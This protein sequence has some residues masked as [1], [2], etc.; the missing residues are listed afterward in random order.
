MPPGWV[1]KQRVIH[2]F[3][4][5]RLCAGFCFAVRILISAA[6]AAS[7]RTL[8]CGSEANISQ[9]SAW[10]NSVSVARRTLQM[11]FNFC[12]A[13]TFKTN[14]NFDYAR[15][16]S[17]V[18][19]FSLWKLQPS[20]T[21]GIGVSFRRSVIDVISEECGRASSESGRGCKRGASGP[22]APRRRATRRVKNGMFEIV[23][24]FHLPRPALARTTCV[25][26]NRRARL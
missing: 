7:Q 17:I 11:V 25:H 10:E 4:V 13:K 8:E 3:P 16:K 12:T 6:D 14:M 15:I 19:R 5:C 1:N 21:L 9:S 26:A 22:T 20:T 2:E 18:Y 24:G 23:N